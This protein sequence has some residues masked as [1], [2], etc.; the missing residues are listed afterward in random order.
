M[1]DQIKVKKMLSE[2]EDEEEWIRE[3]ENVEE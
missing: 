2:I 3:K 1:L